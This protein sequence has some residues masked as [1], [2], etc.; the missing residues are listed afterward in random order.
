MYLTKLASIHLVNWNI[1]EEYNQNPQ[2]IF[3]QAGLDPGHMYQPGARYPLDRVS[4]L[5]EE[6]S[7]CIKDPC[8][9]LLAGSS[10]HPSNFGA[11]GY[12]L[13]MSKSLRGTLE[14]LIR[15]HRIISDDRF[16]EII[17][18]NETKSLKFV[19]KSR[20][21]KEY[22]PARED[23]ALAWLVSVLRVNFQRSLD[24]VSIKIIHD[25]P[26]CAA[27]YFEHFKCPVYF[28]A[29][30]SGVEI[31][32]EDA[33]RVL[34]SFNEEMLELEEKAMTKYLIAREN[35][36][37][38]VRVTKKIVEHLPSGTAT[39]ENT[40]KEL[41]LSTR[42]LQRLLQEQGITFIELIKTTRKSIALEYI[43]DKNM[44]LTEIAFLLGYSEQSTFSRSFKKWTGKS[45]SK[46]RKNVKDW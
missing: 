45:P 13:L 2:E 26:S 19:L 22:L 24:L 3:N 21:E 18:D 35:E 44:D 1:L 9:G 30:T 43:K 31:K 41:H 34:P 33:D 5:W 27:K 39:L 17:E 10:W 20:D 7:N 40:A 6:M 25:R 4:L 36:P 37:L 15:F 28:N 11:L 12:A 32:L 23:A 16:G 42:K 38:L 46:Y 29:K 8:F 14:R